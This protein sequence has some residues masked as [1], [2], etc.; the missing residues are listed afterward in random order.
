MKQILITGANG[1][2]GQHLCKHL[3]LSGYSI[4]AT[5][6]GIRRIPQN[7]EVDYVQLDLTDRPELTAFLRHHSFDVIIH[8]AAMSKPD[9]CNNDREACISTNV[10]AT[11]Y[12]LSANTNHFIYISTDFVFGEN[13]PHAEDA[14][15]GPLNF[16]GETKLHAEELVQQM[17]D[18]F[19]IVRPVFIYGANW[20]GMRPSFLHFVRNSIQ[21]EKNIKVVSDQL[22]T[23]TYAPDICKGIETI[24]EQR[25]TGAFHLAGKDIISPYS[26]ALVTAQVLQLDSSYIEAV[27]AD[28]FPEPVKRAQRSGLMIHK[29]IRD[30]DYQP[31]S[32]EEG[33]RLTFGLA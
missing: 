32:F 22:R 11:K 28:S 2:L 3:S 25:S 15:K 26:M 30:L 23:P 20:R 31:V 27:T 6:R 14:V 24:I 1:F 7:I 21:D 17:A 13:G 19:T 29:A 4:V 10:E 12:I 16:Y 9:E 18:V 5:G 8:N 33:V